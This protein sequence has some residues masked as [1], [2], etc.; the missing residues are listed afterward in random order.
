MTKPSDQDSARR[1]RDTLV[2]RA[3]IVGFAL[4]LLAYVIPVAISLF[5]KAR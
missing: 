4:L 1:R 5:S 2:G 3:V